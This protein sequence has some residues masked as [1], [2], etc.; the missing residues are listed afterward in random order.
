M[1]SPTTNQHPLFEL[2][3]RPFFLLAGILSCLSLGVWVAQLNGVVPYASA[4]S[5]H[6]WHAEQLLFGFAA[7]VAIGFLLTAVQT[8]TGLSSI[9][10]TPLMA[11]TLIW[12]SARLLL[13]ANHEPLMVT[14]I[15][16]QTIGW[17]F[18]WF[19]FARLLIRSRNQRNYLLL[20][21]ILILGTINIST[22]ILDQQGQTELAL[23]LL[24]TT[25]LLFTVLITLI[26]GRVLPMFTQNGL[27]REG[28]T[29][30]S[31]KAPAWLEKIILPITLLGTA[32]FFVGGLVELPFTPAVLLLIIG[33][34]HL[35]RLCHWYGH[36]TTK[37]SLLWSLHLPYGFMAIGLA[38][39]GASYWI[40]AL[41]LSDALHLLTV[42]TVGLMILSMMSRVSLGHTGRP[43]HAHKAVTTA[44]V[45]ML[46][47]AVV[48]FW[49]PQLGQWIPGWTLSGA[50]WIGSMIIFVW[51]YQPILT[52]P[53]ATTPS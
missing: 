34:L 18:A 47:A 7:T 40:D 51:I 19:S 26:G 33:A 41:R 11:L 28:I 13:L 45:L 8:W 38:T 39:L 36:R 12:V 6:V 14:A 25:V 10:G 43:L 5:P 15:T 21:I 48:R 1:T 24:R 4:I 35:V 3:F 46:G 37:V 17:L 27:R 53:R 9:S 2:T 42:G 30:P 29:I 22:L 44:F 31:P 32:I 50:L 52:S 49:L 20:P 16:L 23:H